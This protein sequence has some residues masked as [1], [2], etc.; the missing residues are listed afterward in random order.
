[1][2]FLAYNQKV[3]KHTLKGSASLCTLYI[4]VPPSLGADELFE[5]QCNLGQ[6]I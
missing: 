3:K 2:L 6:K 5:I 1:M 4:G